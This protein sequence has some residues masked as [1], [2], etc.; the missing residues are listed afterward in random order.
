MKVVKII[1]AIVLAFSAFSALIQLSATEEGYGLVGVL[2]AFFGMMG[3]SVLLIWSATKSNKKDYYSVSAGK[4]DANNSYRKKS[5]VNHSMACNML[6]N[7]NYKEALKFANIS[8]ELNPNNHFAMDTRAEIKYYLHDFNGALS[9]VEKSIQ[10]DASNAIKF[11]HRGYFYKT[12]GDLEKAINDWKTA[13]QMGYKDAETP[14]RKYAPEVLKLRAESQLEDISK[15]KDLIENVMNGEALIQPNNNIET[16]IYKYCIACGVKYSP[17]PETK[18]C[19]D[20]G[21]KQ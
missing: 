7:K 6:K 8:I 14:L 2:I 18:Y 13:A 19:K 12:L 17:S 1:I 20:C 21:T 5:T 11:Y 9:D 15:T 16:A 3:G 10:L 4:S